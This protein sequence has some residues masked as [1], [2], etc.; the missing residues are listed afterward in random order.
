[1]R[2]LALPTLAQSLARCRGSS[3]S[4][5]HSIS[6]AR[7]SIIVTE[8]ILKAGSDLFRE[9]RDSFVVAGL[10]TPIQHQLVARFAR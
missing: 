10:G 8:E 6:P 1:L 9:R 4:D 5:C 2:R 7:H 3:R